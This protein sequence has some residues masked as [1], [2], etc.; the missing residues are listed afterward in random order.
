MLA[1]HVFAGSNPACVSIF[2]SL[3]KWPKTSACLADYHQ[4]ESGTVRHFRKV[5]Q[6]ERHTV[7]KTAGVDSP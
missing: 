5:G 7:L 1:T 4:F 3:V 6:L 2:A